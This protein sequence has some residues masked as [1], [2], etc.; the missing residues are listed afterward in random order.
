[1]GQLQF[2]GNVP[3]VDRRTGGKVEV[4]VWGVFAGAGIEPHEE[5]PIREWIMNALM[6]SALAFDGDVYE[7]PKIAGEWGEYVSQ[8]I[9]PQLAQYFKAHGQLQIHG[10]EVAGGAPVSAKQSGPTPASSGGSLLEAAASALA[11]RMGVPHDQ[12]RQAA[13]IV[14]EVV[15]GHGGSAKDAYAKDAHAKEPDWKK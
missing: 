8:Q 11:S 7:L 14:L 13:A 6:S 4:R 2:S 12:A 9:S 1:M 10:I 5:Q 15:Q 3:F